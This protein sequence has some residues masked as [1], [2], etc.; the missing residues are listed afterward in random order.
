MAP[1]WHLNATEIVEDINF[2]FCNYD[3]VVN[4]TVRSALATVGFG[5]LR[6]FFSAVLTFHSCDLY[7]SSDY[8]DEQE[9]LLCESDEGCSVDLPVPYFNIPIFGEPF[10]QVSMCGTLY[11]TYVTPLDIRTLVYIQSIP[12]WRR[13]ICKA[14][15]A[16]SHC[17]ELSLLL[18]G[19]IERIIKGQIR[20]PDQSFGIGQYDRQITLIAPYRR[21]GK[22]FI[23]GSTSL[24]A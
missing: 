11:G 15:A 10:D 8:A 7:E 2:N 17:A 14:L 20:N 18:L 6:C 22:P 13:R 1:G 21:Q 5:S 3:G 9:E 19:E 4:S 12:R 24:A 16:Y 23:F